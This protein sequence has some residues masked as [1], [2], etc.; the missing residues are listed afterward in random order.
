MVF[1]F[2]S[3]SLLKII[4]VF[5]SFCEDAVCIFNTYFAIVRISAKITG[6]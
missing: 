1:V 2:Q 6:V 4:V 3:Q 5:G